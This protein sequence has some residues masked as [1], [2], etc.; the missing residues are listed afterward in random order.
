MLDTV[1][2]FLILA[3]FFAA[4]IDTALGMC[5]GTL[6]TPILLLG[7]FPPEVI[8]PTVLLS[9]LVVDVSGGTA[10]I[11]VKNF[12]KNDVRTALLVGVPATA[13][14]GL[15]A[16]L[17]VNLPASVTKIYIGVL[18][19]F[20]GLLLLLGIKL[21]KTSKR[22]VFISAAAGF[23]KGFMGGGF[24]PVVVPGQIVLNHDP[25]PSIAIGDIAEISVCIVGLLT[26]ALLGKLSLSP[27]YIMVTIPALLASLIGPH[28]TRMFAERGYADRL[29]GAVTLLL[30]IIGLAKVLMGG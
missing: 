12:T 16:L 18:V 15:G 6:L 24:G 26:F 28:I 29:V 27:I 11:K 30:G 23:N 14:V 25:R 4:L 3:A 5:Y 21:R 10:H 2:L 13:F 20:L 22:L 1:S 9:Q 19:T 8:V 7:G 17:N